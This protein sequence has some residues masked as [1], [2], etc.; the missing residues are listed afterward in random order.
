VGSKLAI[1]AVT[2]CERPLPPLG[3]GSPRQRL[4]LL[5]AYDGRAFRGWQS[6]PNGE[7]VQD[8]LRHALG[9][10][11][12]FDLPVVGSGRTDSGVHA[13]GQV[14]HVDVP[15]QRYSMEIWQRALNAHLPGAVRVLRCRPAPF[16]FHAQHSAKC[17][18]YLYRIC[19]G[20]VLHPLEIGR[21][22]HFSP[23]LD[24]M[25][26]LTAACELLTGTHDFA[27]FAANRGQPER[28]TVRTLYAVQARRQ[29]ALLTL[30]FEGNGFLYRMVRLLTGSLLQV[31][32]AKRTLDWLEALLQAKPGHKTNH[33]APPDGLYLYRVRYARKQV[34]E[35][36]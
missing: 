19:L 20:P 2:A 36:G 33:C 6:Q 29:S 25:Q 12:R 9:V 8:H 15:A 4:K 13:L 23:P 21:A 1:V 26:A 5:L 14:A 11:T 34:S 3:V 27:A 10:I 30:R 35:R 32:A 7:G 18:T 16:S 17:K 28:T 24:G 22:W 31:A